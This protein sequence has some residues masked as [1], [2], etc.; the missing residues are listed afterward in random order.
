[1]YSN[2]HFQSVKLGADSFLIEVVVGDPGS[3]LQ[4]GAI[5]TNWCTT[6]IFYH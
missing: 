2:D 6:N 4:I 1:M 3:L 5:I